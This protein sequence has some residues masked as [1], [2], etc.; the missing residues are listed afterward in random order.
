G[1]RGLEA[2]GRVGRE[3][4]AAVEPV[5]VARAVA[6]VGDGAGEPAAGLGVE[7]A[8]AAAL[9]DDLDPI[10]ARRPD[11]E[12][13]PSRRDLGAERQHGGDG[14]PKTTDASGW[15]PGPPPRPP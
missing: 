15:P 6:G 12:P 14:R 9:D 1:P 13:D 8:R 2:G 7:R 10:S 5:A 4:R 3:G 11:A